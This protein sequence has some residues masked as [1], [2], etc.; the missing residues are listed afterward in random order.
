MYFQ[1][2]DEIKHKKVVAIGKSIRE[3]SRLRKIYGDGKWRKM[4]GITRVR[5]SDKTICGVEIHSYEAHGIE[6]K[7]FKIKR[8]ID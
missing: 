1:I 8:I 6:K 7:E 4:K 3:I 5:L 2:I